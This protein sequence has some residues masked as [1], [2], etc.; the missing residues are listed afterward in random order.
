MEPLVLV[1]DI[2]RYGG[3]YVAT[4]SFKDNDVLTSGD[5]P[6]KVYNEARSKGIDEPVVFYV[7]EKD[8]VYIYPCQ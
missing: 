8:V 1:N 4:K 6:V 7:P 5:D 3:K 2:D